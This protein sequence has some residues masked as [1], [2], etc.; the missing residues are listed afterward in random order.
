MYI[1]YI[2]SIY[3]YL[4]IT[5]YLGKPTQGALHDVGWSPEEA[6]IIQLRLRFDPRVTIDVNVVGRFVLEPGK[7]W[8]MGIPGRIWFMLV[9]SPYMCIHIYI[10]IYTYMYIL[11]IYKYIVYV[12][13]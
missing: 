11:Y 2:Y 9:Y 10:Y 6:P 3:I 12:Y 5:L 4:Y 8:A 1:L 7:P 13:T